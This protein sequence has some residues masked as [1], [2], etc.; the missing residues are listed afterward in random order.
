MGI[1]GSVVECLATYD[2]LCYVVLGYRDVTLPT[3]QT[4]LLLP[5]TE[6]TVCAVALYFTS[7]SSLRYRC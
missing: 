6:Y 7:S 4:L 5:H 1:Y 3:S 2:L